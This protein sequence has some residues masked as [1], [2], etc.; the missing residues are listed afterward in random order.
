MKIFF[1]GIHVIYYIIDVI[2]VDARKNR[3]TPLRQLKEKTP[4][5]EGNG[6][7]GKREIEKAGKG[8]GQYEKVG[9][10]KGHIVNAGKVKGATPPPH[11]HQVRFLHN[12]E[13]RFLHKHQIRFLHKR[14]VRFLQ[15]HQ[16]SFLHTHQLS[17]LYKN[18]TQFPTHDPS[19]SQF[20]SQ[21]PVGTSNDL[22]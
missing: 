13:V 10:D 8:K 19:Q 20:P 21:A 14:Q 17:F 12:N 11:K 9:R 16:L 15:K 2:H 18:L 3:G 7:K 4:S 1:I 5:N 22:R 6:G